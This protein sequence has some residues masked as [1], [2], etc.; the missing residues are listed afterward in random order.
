MVAF[1]QLQDNK[2]AWS[3]C[4]Q[5]AERCSEWRDAIDTTGYTLR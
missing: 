4:W 3:V 5:K 2:K 1:S